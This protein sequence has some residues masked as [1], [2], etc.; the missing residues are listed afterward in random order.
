MPL[1][2]EEDVPTDPGDV[3]FLGPA[4][5]MSN[6]VGRA[7]TIEQAWLRWLGRASFVDTGREAARDL[8]EERLVRDGPSH[9]NGPGLVE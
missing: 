7:D 6:P 1:A 2:V 3:G 8:T 4:T 5:V 9:G